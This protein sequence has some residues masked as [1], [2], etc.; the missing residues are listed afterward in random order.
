[1]IPGRIQDATRVLGAPPSWDQQTEL[2]CGALPVREMIVDRM[3]CLVSAWLP[4]EEEMA[5][6]A[7]G[8]PVVL[9]IFSRLHPV[10]AIGVG[11]PPDVT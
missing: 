10:V 7:A 5:A 9:H 3:P 1:M 4:T 6:I 11:Q 8:A 2:P